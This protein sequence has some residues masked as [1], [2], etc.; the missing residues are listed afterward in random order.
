[1][2]KVKVKVTWELELPYDTEEQTYKFDA[3]GLVIQDVFDN[4]VNYAI[5][6]HLEDS[7]EYLSKTKGN[8]TSIFYEIFKH[9]EF[10]ADLLRKA[11]TEGKVNYEV[12]LPK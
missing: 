4:L 3:K 5:L 11:E 9:H 7:M 1:M 10:W 8:K 2:K 6:K 12:E